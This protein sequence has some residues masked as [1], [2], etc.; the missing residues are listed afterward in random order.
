[1][2]G[3]APADYARFLEYAVRL[4]LLQRAGGGYLFI[5]RL[6]LEHFA[7]GTAAA[8]P[9]EPT[10]GTSMASVVSRPVGP[11]RAVTVP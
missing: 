1:V 6:L 3:Y 2:R 8:P 11:T 4:V 5:H 7:D 9:S 10:P